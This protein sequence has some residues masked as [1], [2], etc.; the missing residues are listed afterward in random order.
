MSKVV[1]SRSTHFFILS[2]NSTRR[3]MAS[4]PFSRNPTITELAMRTI[5][6]IFVLALVVIAGA[7]YSDY[8]LTS[9]ESAP[10]SAARAP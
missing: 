7:F 9:S 3:R 5:A 4:A 2:P 1:S 10:A 8:E 6:V